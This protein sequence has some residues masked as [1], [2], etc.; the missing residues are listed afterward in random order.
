MATATATPGAY[1]FPWGVDNTQRF[2]EIRGTIGISASPDTY[3]TGGLAVNW[4]QMA[5]DGGF[6]VPVN[7]GSLAVP[8]GV[9]FRSVSGSGYIYE[10]NA[11]NNTIQI[12]VQGAAAGDALAE[13][14]DLAAI[15]AGVSNDN[16]QFEATFTKYD[17]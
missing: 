2:I 16:V 15:P 7:A 13:M 10:W 8:V 14:A 6:E 11:T 17:R 12:F 5:V 3:A 4:T 1:P 9:H